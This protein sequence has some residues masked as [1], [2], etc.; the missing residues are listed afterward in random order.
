MAAAAAAALRSLSQAGVQTSCFV[1]LQLA[2]VLTSACDVI[3]FG[4]CY[5]GL[6]SLRLEIKA[7][8]VVDVLPSYTP[9]SH[10]IGNCT[11]GDFEG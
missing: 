8:A 11:Q 1:G 9:F 6:E 7:H 2:K 4:F 3:D 5:S 10:V